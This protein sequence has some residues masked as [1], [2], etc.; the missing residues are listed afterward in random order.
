MIPDF[1]KIAKRD[2]AKLREEAKAQKIK[3]SGVSSYDLAV[4]LNHTIRLR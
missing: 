4:M 3:F 1:E 2:R